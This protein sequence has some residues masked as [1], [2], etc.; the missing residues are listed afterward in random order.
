MMPMTVIGI[1]CR[2]RRGR[3]GSAQE[4]SSLHVTTMVY[5]RG[6]QVELD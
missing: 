1:K 4:F 3:F 2:N 5:V 6:L